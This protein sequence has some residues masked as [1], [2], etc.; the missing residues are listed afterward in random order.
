[1]PARTIVAK[2][3]RVRAAYLIRG[4]ALGVLVAIMYGC[5]YGSGFFLVSWLVLAL[6]IMLGQWWPRAIVG[7]LALAA[8]IINVQEHRPVIAVLATLMIVTVAIPGRLLVFF[9]EP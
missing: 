3:P 8:V 7:A 1:M 4:C 2:P 5:G 9:L 6:F